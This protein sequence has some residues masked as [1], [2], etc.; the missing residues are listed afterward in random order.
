VS[1]QLTGTD[2]NKTISNLLEA[3]A[4]LSS[5]IST[6]RS[7]ARV[8]LQPWGGDYK[9]ASKDIFGNNLGEASAQY[10]YTL[11]EIINSSWFIETVRRRK[12]KNSTLDEKNT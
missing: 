3:S 2:T 4:R 9:A 6:L 7:E 11:N 10:K 8:F 12:S 5:M 1:N